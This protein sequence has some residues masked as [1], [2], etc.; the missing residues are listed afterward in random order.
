[1]TTLGFTY[2]KQEGYA[3]FYD[4][5]DGVKP[6]PAYHKEFEDYCLTLSSPWYMLLFRK[7]IK[8][9]ASNAWDNA[10][11]TKAVKEAEK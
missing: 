3:M 9:I 5:K 4:N 11:S 6:W 10:L 1:M 8:S 7:Y 2:P